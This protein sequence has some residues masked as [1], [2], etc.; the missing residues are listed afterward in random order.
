M[1]VR[2]FPSLRFATVA[3]HFYTRTR[4]GAIANSRQTTQ[5]QKEF[6]SKKLI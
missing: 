1:R 6:P 4:E 5:E 2:F 3:C